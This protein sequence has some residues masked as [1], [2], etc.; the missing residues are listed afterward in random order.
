MDE[1][2]ILNKMMSMYRSLDNKISYFRHHIILNAIFI[3]LFMAV[4]VISYLNESSMLLK[5]I[6]SADIFV[7]VSV[8][9]VVFIWPFAFKFRFMCPRTPLL[10][11]HLHSNMELDDLYKSYGKYV[12][13]YDDNFLMWVKDTEYSYWVIL[14]LHLIISIVSLFYR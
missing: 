7:T 11:R 6:Y 5:N 2:I 14:F 3:N 9:V 8:L 13:N 4:S 10:H 12:N 1:K